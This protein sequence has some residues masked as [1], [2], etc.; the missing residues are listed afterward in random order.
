MF[1]VKI[2]VH[3]CGQSKPP[4]ADV[5]FVIITPDLARIRRLMIN[6]WPGIASL[7]LIVMGHVMM[8]SGDPGQPGRVSGANFLGWI[9]PIEIF[10]I[11]DHCIAAVGPELWMC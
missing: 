8:S 10:C 4:V 7:P 11:L 5:N 2:M 1:S 3:N 9:I 6:S